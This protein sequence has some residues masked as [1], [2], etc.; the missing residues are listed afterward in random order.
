M[1]IKHHSFNGAEF[2]YLLRF[3]L[4][5]SETL[6]KFVLPQNPHTSLHLLFCLVF[7]Y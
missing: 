7:A 5:T 6:V 3:V 4:F 1:K 2:K